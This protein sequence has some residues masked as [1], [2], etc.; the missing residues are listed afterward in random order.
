MGGYSTP[1][2][3]I[4]RL[5]VTLTANNSTASTAHNMGKTPNILGRPNPDKLDGLD[6]YGSADGTNITITC[7]AP[8]SSDTI[9]TFDLI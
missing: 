4:K 1:S 2:F 6:S 8:V 7:N 3:S 9:F 5:T